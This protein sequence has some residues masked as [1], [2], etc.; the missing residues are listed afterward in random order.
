M[1]RT[2][3]GRYWVIGTVVVP[4]LVS[5]AS[6]VG[7]EFMAMRDEL[8]VLRTEKGQTDRGKEVWRSRFA[9]LERGVAECKHELS[10]LASR[11]RP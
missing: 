2:G 6:W 8:T 3:T 5:G 10:T 11:S 4:L 1:A 9:E 7:K